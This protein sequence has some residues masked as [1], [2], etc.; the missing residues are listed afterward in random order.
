[1]TSLPR[2][3]PRRGLLLGV[4]GVV[5]LIGALPV[6][7]GE[8]PGRL[9]DPLPIRRVWLTPDCLAAE[10]E[11]AKPGV[12]VP[13]PRQDFEDR[14]RQAAR[15][16]HAVKNP[17]R[18]VEARYHAVL[19]PDNALDGACEWKVIHTADAPGLLGLKPLNL[20]L[21]QPRFE[22]RD[23]LIADFDGRDPALLVEAAGEH[24]VAVEWSARGEARPDGVRFN[25]ELPPCPVTVVELDLPA[26]RIAAAEGAVL[27]GPLP[28][29]KPDRRRWR[30][31]CGGRSQLTL[32]VRPA[33]GVGPPPLLLANQRTT[34]TLAADGLDALFEFDL[35]A[36]HQGARELVFE[37]D[38][39]LRPYDVSAPGLAKWEAPPPEA[40]GPTRIVVRLREPLDKGTV[41]VRCLG[42]LGPAADG[43]AGESRPVQWTSPAVRLAAAVPAGETLVVKAHPEL[44][45]E[46]WEPNGFRLTE[47]ATEADEQKTAWRRLTMVG[48]GAAG[49]ARPKARLRPRAVEFRA[50][51][52]AWW[53]VQPTGA[54]L[55][56]QI[57]YRVRY[58]QLFDLQVQLPADWEVDHVDLSP[59]ALLRDWSVKTD[60]GRSVLQVDLQRPLG[61]SDAAEAP[62][63]TLT[64]SLQPLR[65]DDVTGR[66]QPFP[67]PTPLGARFREGALAI[68][69]DGRTH[70]LDVKTAAAEEAVDEDGPWGK[71][72]PDYFYPYRAAIDSAQPV[73][74]AAVLRQ[75][76]PQVRAHCSTEAY[77]SAARSEA[78]VRLSLEAE[79]GAPDAVDLDVAG[80]DGRPWKWEVEGSGP[81][82]KR[83][84]R[85]YAADAVAAASAVGWSPLEAAMRLTALP[86]GER[87]RLTFDRPLRIHEPLHLRAVRPLMQEDD[88]WETPLAAIA[89]PGQMEGEA[90]LHLAAVGPIQFE[91]V[92]LREAAPPANAASL[93][94]GGAW[95]FFCY[96]RAPVCLTLRGRLQPADRAA[97]GVVGRAELT[98]AVGPNG[99]L[100]HHYAF[101]ATDWPDRDLPLRL[102]AGA[103]PT[104]AK[105]DGVWVDRIATKDDAGVPVLLLPVPNQSGVGS[106]NAH[107]FEVTYT[108]TAPIGWL[109][110]QISSPAP[111]PPAAPVGIRRRWRLPPG[112]APLGDVSR[113]AGPG[114][115]MAPPDR[116]FAPSDVFRPFPAPML[117]PPT[118]GETERRDALTA[119][120][121]ALHS[122]GEITTTLGEIIA[123]TC[124][125][126]RGRGELVV[127][128][129]ALAEAGV[130]RDARLTVRPLR[131]ADNPEPWAD[132][133][134]ELVATRPALLLTTRR[135]AA[136][137]RETAGAA[138]T[139]ALESAMA[140]AAR[141]GRDAAG[142]FRSASAWLEDGAAS[143]GEGA[144]PA[145]G[146][147]PL[148]WTEWEAPAGAADPTSLRVVQPGLAWW[149][150]ILAV[151]VVGLPL[152]IA[153]YR[154][155]ALRLG[156]MLG[157]LAAAGVVVYWL[158]TPLEGLARPAL[159]VGCGV[160]LLAF[161][162]W[163]SRGRVGPA[164]RRGAAAAAGATAALLLLGVA[165]RG[166][167][168]DS[169]E[170]AVVY[171]IPGPADAPEKE[172]VLAPLELL[173]QLRV[174]SQPGSAAVL[175]GAVYDGRVVDGAA[176]F[177][178][179]FQAYSLTDEPATLTIPLAGAPLM[180]DVLLDGAPARPTAA[181]A[182]QTGFTLPVKGRGRHK[183]ELHFRAVVAV[184]GEERSLVFS[185]PRQLQSRLTFL[186][187]KGSA[188]LQAV[189]R[190]GAQ[191]VTAEA[192]GVRVEAELGRLASPVH[193]RWFPEEWLA[194]KADV[195][196]KEAYLWDLKPDGC[197]LTAFLAYTVSDGAVS[198]LTVGL[199]PE[200][201]ARNVE[202][203]RPKDG[204]AIRVRD[205]RTVGAGGERALEIDF[206][207]PLTGELELTL[208]LAPRAPLP[209]TGILPLPTPR[210]RRVRDDGGYLAYRSFDLDV[211][212]GNPLGVTGVPEEK[213]AP[214]WPAAAR[215]KPTVPLAYACFL[216]RDPDNPPKLEVKMR[217]AAAVGRAAVNLSLRVGPRQADVTAAV[218]LTEMNRELSLVE[219]EIASPQPFAIT[220]VT[221]PE[222][223]RWT[224]AG[225]RLLVWLDRPVKERVK[226]EIVGWLPLAGGAKAGDPLRLELPCLRVA[227]ARAQQT[228][229]RLAAEAEV[230]LAAPKLKNLAAAQGKPSD[231]ELE[232]TSKQADYGGVWQVNATPIEARVYTFVGAADGT[233]T[234]TSVVDFASSQGRLRSA[235]VRLRRW[236]GAE[237]R[238][239]APGAA[240]PP[241]ERRRGNGERTWEVELGADAGRRCRLTLTG[242]V[243][244]AAAGIM[245]PDVSVPGAGG[246]PPGVWA[247]RQPRW[248]AAAG[249][250]LTA[251]GATGLAPVDPAKE[252]AGVEFSGEA[253][254]LRRLGGP[255]WKLTDPEWD[256]RLQPHDAKSGATSIHVYLAEYSAGVV[257]G[258]RWLHE[259][260]YWLRHEADA[261]LNIAFPAEADVLSAAVDGV[262]TTPLQ[263]DARR[264]WLPLTGRPA[265]CRVRLRWRYDAAAEPLER[266]NL[267]PPILEGASP[268][269]AVWTA[270]APPGWVVDPA[271]G[272]GLRSGPAQRA[273]LDLERAEAQF[274]IVAHLAPRGDVAA[275]PLVEARRHFQR[276]LRRATRETEAISVGSEATAVDG[277]PLVK[278]LQELQERRDSLA[279]RHAFEEISADGS[280]TNDDDWIAN[281]EGEPLH[282]RT[283]ADDSAPGPRFIPANGGRAQEAWTASGAWLGI[284]IGVAL[285]AIIPGLTARLRPLWPEL[286]AALGAVGWG[287]AGPTPVVLFLLL[288][289]ACGRV[290]LLGR[291]VS[292]LLRRRPATASASSPG[293]PRS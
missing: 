78:T 118:A 206:T 219:W 189:V 45:L 85:L 56:L 178:A 97:E 71:I 283:E 146:L 135:Q 68:S 114:E 158:P 292:W 47:T 185:A 14:V 161:L 79:R 44:R 75:R 115:G 63:A 255:A 276:L 40:G 224:H 51:Q 282:A 128:V 106:R 130:D 83:Q 177:D 22:N 242:S 49:A 132:L 184:T 286:L 244:F 84:E 281:A 31:A 235:T 138:P 289:A 26:D 230:A 234:F 53:R 174:L 277:R 192:D 291:G 109:W 136:Q 274:Q 12:L 95:R 61:P 69:F 15:A 221:G 96:T 131:P 210:G 21:R 231:Q 227:A 73:Q 64:L 125:F 170:P 50:R 133:Q 182:P 37:C 124:G 59:P 280:A 86:R 30:A 257:D 127:D 105:L 207:S 175:V 145:P 223:G 270:V 214:F 143:A 215:P 190:Y 166:G 245:V 266:P 250:D 17:P 269:P 5:A 10:M 228:T 142:R 261:D 240:R 159:L 260:T 212:R 202:A 89:A 67:V 284:L 209:A 196:F 188:Q 39:G 148:T 122:R 162:F 18:L 80:G 171:L 70:R 113:L 62:A 273:A 107:R 101:E 55:T 8:P 23:A 2:P 108:T 186:A 126:L 19:T 169:N 149:A 66:E 241:R 88:R 216:P 141:G 100:E 112:F 208:D 157:W 220:A 46:A 74:G 267:A 238:L 151:V 13:L 102:P 48:G 94:A 76:P 34:Q 201:E 217:P 264:L 213:F 179:V 82:I 57:A 172:M 204:G 239:D 183:V 4:S 24:A 111:A 243:P 200:L 246:P 58:G 252:W 103:K 218:E 147:A 144:P 256:L 203:R 268:G 176:Q 16:A 272:G 263:P 225:D 153:A 123:Q 35:T 93:R 278:T 91:V 275:G 233:L 6:A 199:P 110:T 195:Q 9:A 3:S 290:F 1:M 165:G 222:V 271:T 117:G 156:L 25:L 27:T 285:A 180:G 181:V 254:R 54:R 197:G 293:G 253:E 140:T 90:M 41:Q 152:A 258:R 168:A 265:A 154:F 29:E 287:L 7:L 139:E 60:A 134:L 198:S 248:L 33:E 259:A 160:A 288:A 163:A 32:T 116:A 36:I 137:W 173:D 43:P 42:P 121:T 194:R 81:M 99:L 164:K 129:A 191:R 236:D 72:I 247:G 150:G 237:V 232:Y 104:T 28:A 167:P 98:T 87:W 279:K 226:L 20:A 193:L 92:G 155:R 251:E 38:A 187:P 65:S 249:P 211:E 119:A 262:E 11:R 52:L 205:W 120:L 77:L 229:V